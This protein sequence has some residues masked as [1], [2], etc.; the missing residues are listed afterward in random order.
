MESFSLSVD[1]QHVAEII[2]AENT[3]NFEEIYLCLGRLSN[4]GWVK[5]E[6]LQRLER[7]NIILGQQEHNQMKTTFQAVDV[8]NQFTVI[9]LT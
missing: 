8:G 7:T 5:M 4:G 2:R 6:N 1:A 3:P 9:D